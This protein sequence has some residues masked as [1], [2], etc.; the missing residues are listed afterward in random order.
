M[1]FDFSLLNIIMKKF[2]VITTIFNPSEAIKRFALLD[3]WNL[4]VVGDK[5][6]PV[7]WNLSGVEYL[8]PGDQLKLGFKISKYLPWNNYARKMVGYL[9]AVRHGADLIAESDDDNYPLPGWGK[10]TSCKKYDIVSGQGFVNIYNYFQDKKELVWPRGFPL[11]QINKENKFNVNKGSRKIGIYQFLVNKQP[12]VDAIYRLTVNKEVNFKLNFIFVLDKGVICPFN[13]QN[14]FFKKE[15]FPLMYLP[16]FTTMRSTDIFR[17]LVAQPLMWLY[18]LYLAF[19]SP[20]AYQERNQ[21][22]YMKDFA[23]EIPVYLGAR[24]VFDVVEK[25]LSSNKSLE[26]NLLFAYS[27]LI[28]NGILAKEEFELLESWLE[29]LGNLVR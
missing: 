5:K 23:D 11:D 3:D 20:T 28:R 24:K 4:V 15:V 8:S 16:S 6:T 12:D 1:I 29:D 9:Y 25:N 7:G 26:D 18:D 21:H 2:L 10:L 27:A 13:S 14:T 22:N 17:G 19:A